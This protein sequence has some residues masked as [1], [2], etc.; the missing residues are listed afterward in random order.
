MTYADDVKKFMTV[1]GQAVRSEPTVI[2]DIEKWQ[3]F[4][5]LN[6]E[7]SEMKKALIEIKGA[8]ENHNKAGTKTALAELGD[9]LTDIVYVAIGSAHAYGLDFDGMWGEVQ[10][11]NMAKF[12]DG[13]AVRDENNKVVK[14][15]D[16]AAPDIKGVLF[17]SKH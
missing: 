15:H 12:P 16:W 14:P 4:E 5:Y 10:S 7:F 13:V 2:S 1:A 3:R 6:E 8:S 17:P 11:S 9:A